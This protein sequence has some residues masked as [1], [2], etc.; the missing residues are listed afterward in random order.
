MSP[1]K[2]KPAL[3]WHVYGGV[4][5]GDC[6]LGEGLWMLMIIESLTVPGDAPPSVDTP[7]PLALLASLDHD[8]TEDEREELTPE[9][10]RDRPVNAVQTELRV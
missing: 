8:P 4:T 2:K 9:E 1:A 5:S 7:W 6:P 10:F 3:W